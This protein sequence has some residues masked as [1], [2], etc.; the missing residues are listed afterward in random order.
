MRFGNPFSFT[1]LPVTVILSIAYIALITPLLVTH[2]TVPAAPANPVHIKGLN[3]T[4]AF[5]D[6]QELSN[7]YHPYNSRRN[8]EVR[9]WILRRLEGIL[10]D[11]GVQFG[12]EMRGVNGTTRTSGSGD[13]V[14]FSD[15]LSNVTVS[16]SG[17]SQGGVRKPG[18]T[19]YF[20][21]TNVMVYIRGSED[22]EGQWWT[23]DLRVG[24]THGK[25]GVL[26]N[27]H[28]DSVSTGF[29]ATD[30][31]VGVISVLQ[32]VKYFTTPGN[33][34]KKGVVA[35]LNNG[36][37][38]FLNGI[39]AFTQHP[40]SEFVHTFLNLEGAGAGGR[41]TLFRTTDTEVTRAYQG[42][43]HPFGT[44]VSA[45]GFKSGFVR[46]QTDYV[47]LEDVLGLRGLDLAFWHPRA[48]YHTNQDDARHTSVD[49][50][51]H[52]LEASLSTM[53]SLT[54]DTSSTFDGP[55][56]D[57]AKGKAKNGKGSDGVWFDLFGRTF[58]VFGLRS[59]FAWSLTLLIA[60]PLILIVLTFLL[61]RSDRYYLFAGKFPTRDGEAAVN[62]GG[63]RGFF[64]FPIALVFSLAVALG[65]A[66]LITKV[67]PFIIYSSSYA[68]WTTILSA[69]FLVFWFIFSGAAFVRPSAVSRT[70]AFLWLFTLGWMVLV[71][72]TVFE[73]RFKIA[74]GYFLVIFESAV[75]LAAFVGLCELFALPTK[76]D[77]AA[78]VREEEDA[79]DATSA[80]PDHDA[81]LAPTADEHDEE[82]T[83]TTP[84][85]GGDGHRPSTAPTFGTNY[86]RARS[87]GASINT[88]G[89]HD[90]PASDSDKNSPFGTEQRWSSSLP[91]W[92][93]V[94]QFLL[95]G[96]ITIITSAQIG[97]LL[98]GAVNQ[99]GADGNP[100]LTTYAIIAFFSTLI[101]LPLTPF[102][103]RVGHRI[104]LFLLLVFIGTL[105]Y[106]LV[107]FPFSA[108]NRYKVYFRQTLDLD[109]GVNTVYLAGIEEYVKAIVQEL[110]SAAGKD[111]TCEADSGRVGL[112]S[113]SFEGLSPHVVPNVPSVAGVPPQKGYEQWMEAKSTRTGDSTARFEVKG[114][115]SRAC[116]LKFDR[117]VIKVSVDGAGRDDR[118]ESVSEGGSSMVKLWR[119]EWGVGWAVD[120]E[121]ALENFDE[122]AGELGNETLNNM[123]AKGMDGEVLCLW[124]DANERGRIPA[125]DEVLRF[126]PVWVAVSKFGDGLVEGV[127]RF[128]V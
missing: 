42:T 67:N 51:W 5:L 62:F 99:T 15:L 43:K 35:L 128:V 54:S 24:K 80:L 60:A 46:S 120:V 75:F 77:Y 113:C 14:L 69:Q 119:R 105:I 44:V 90:S 81:L 33:R 22:E 64:R 17:V 10:G 48:R 115:E 103:H 100:L 55:R 27:A 57:G 88:D 92:T 72:V 76:R 82:A 85:F 12:T 59:L 91:S 95:V 94:L 19:V 125:F 28:Y 58:A 83:E 11:N 104:P 63:W 78:L 127:K 6:L 47:V 112:A 39:R 66:F 79:R 52:M 53:K 3:T 41:A 109:T 25:G 26:V 45:D 36:E 9:D 61:V 21:G 4:E 101:L 37:E 121:W 31:G 2:E 30:D 38:D 98:V 34:P 68:V 122:Q 114:S 87:L 89:A 74:S 32:L 13:V 102:V 23:Q 116:V 123:E 97:L 29:G 18:Q 110:P 16:A 106:N 8:D 111:I 50:L 1:P 107:A 96:P 126:A 70:Y 117:P 108:E 124:S 65:L 49:S 7:G 20:E 40:L 86:R 93:W 84:L 73:D 56:G 71:V 118:F